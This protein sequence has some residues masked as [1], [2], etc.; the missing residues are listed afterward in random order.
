MLLPVNFKHFKDCRKERKNSFE[1]IKILNSMHFT[2]EFYYKL[3]SAMIHFQ[4]PLNCFI[5]QQLKRSCTLELEFIISNVKSPANVIQRTFLLSII[6]DF[7][8]FL[9]EAKTK[10]SNF[11][12]DSS[13]RMPKLFGL[14]MSFILIEFLCALFT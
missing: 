14:S 6:A 2:L 3:Q 5:F 12:D 8:L 9:F 11:S 10:K 7:S 13:K 4:F 1:V